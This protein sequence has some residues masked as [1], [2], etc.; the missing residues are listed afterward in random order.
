MKLY[1]VVDIDIKWFFDNIDHGGKDNYTN[2]IYVD[3]YVY[4]LIHEEKEE[5]IE[6]YKNRLSLDSIGLTKINIL[7]KFVGNYAI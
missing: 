7:R 1:Y 6:K 3:G 4:K 2:L 5:I